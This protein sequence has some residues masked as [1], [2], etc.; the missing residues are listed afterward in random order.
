MGLSNKPRPSSTAASNVKDEQFPN[1]QKVAPGAELVVLG[2]VTVRNTTQ[3]GSLNDLEVKYLEEGRQI[4]LN[5]RS[6]PKKRMSFD[7]FFDFEKFAFQPKLTNASFS[8]GKN[9]RV[10]I[11]TIEPTETP[12]TLQVVLTRQWLSSGTPSTWRYQRG[13]VFLVFLKVSNAEIFAWKKKNR[14]AV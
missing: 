3:V 4:E 9:N 1:W 14:G 11:A 7:F 8:V 2:E 5:F 13:I 12:Q 6:E 10:S